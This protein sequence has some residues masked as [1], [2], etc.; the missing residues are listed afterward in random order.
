M[1]G[2]RIGNKELIK[3]IN[4]YLVIDEIRSTDSISRAQISKNTNLA[5]STITRIVNPLIENNIILEVGDG[6]STGGRKPVKLIFNYDYGHVIAI[7]IEQNHFII[8]LCNLKPS[9]VTFESVKFEMNAS[10]E[11]VK[12][13]LFKSIRELLIKSKTKNQQVYSICISLSGVID[14]ENGMLISST[15][16]N[17][18]NID[19]RKKL[20][21]EFNMDVFIENDSNTFAQYQKDFEYGADVNNFISITV[22]EGIGSG[23]VMNGNLYHGTY[24]GAGEFGHQILYP[25][26]KKCYC[27]QNG[28]LE[29]YASENYIIDNI[30]KALGTHYNYEDIFIKHSVE[31]E[32][33]YNNVFNAYRNIG[34]GIV[35][36]IM[37]LNPEKIILGVKSDLDISPVKNALINQV[38]QNWFS[39]K[40]QLETKIEF[41][42][43][44]NEKFILGV[45]KKS[46]D[47][48]L[49]KPIYNDYQTIF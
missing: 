15:L 34:Y 33:V 1:M 22:G 23:I 28:C 46:I 47:E 40:G 44:E 3:D 36:L 19:L 24:G 45:S 17:W 32:I 35:N 26:G 48:L 6:K 8:S 27:G 5:Q 21:D 14:S 20:Q 13:L 43:L 42:V 41:S 10:F 29:L 30:N 7:K 16:L 31:K 49:G 11:H 12:D 2:L 38:N 9:I 18:Y 39:Q 37:L 4:N 25:E